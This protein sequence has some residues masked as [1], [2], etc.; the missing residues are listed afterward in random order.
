MRRAAHAVPASLA[1]EIIGWLGAILV[2]LAYAC[3][4]FGWITTAH[5][6]FPIMNGLGAL[7]LIIHARTVRDLPIIAL[8]TIW[9]LIALLALRP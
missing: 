8:N 7:A 6:L 2:L 9:L 4:S 3:A 1:I 5:P